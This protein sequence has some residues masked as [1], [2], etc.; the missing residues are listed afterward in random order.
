MRSDYGNA[1][2]GV[3]VLYDR[4]NLKTLPYDCVTEVGV[5]LESALNNYID[6]NKQWD[7]DYSC[8]VDK[9]ALPELRRD[10]LHAHKLFTKAGKSLRGL[11]PR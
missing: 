10:W 4:V 1:L 3:Q 7:N 9:D 8:D 2:G 11:D 6:A 5:P